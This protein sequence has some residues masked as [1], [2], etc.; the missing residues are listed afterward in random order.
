M[1]MKKSLLPTEEDIT[2]ALQT[3]VREIEKYAPEKI[4]DYFSTLFLTPDSEGERRDSRA[5]SK[6]EKIAELLASPEN[7]K[8]KLAVFDELYRRYKYFENTTIEKQILWS[9]REGFRC[10]VMEYV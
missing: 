3:D 4:A 8:K 6:L 7:K 1:I 2:K 10:K 5:E 9:I